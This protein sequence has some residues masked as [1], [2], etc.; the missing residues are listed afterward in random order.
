ML[1]E[2]GALLERGR[3]R[4]VR[5][6]ARWW[7]AGDLGYSFEDSLDSLEDEVGGSEGDRG[8]CAWWR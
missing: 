4:S 6:K 1:D 2:D 8:A 5:G 7:Y 3:S